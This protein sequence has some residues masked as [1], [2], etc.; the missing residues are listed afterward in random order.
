M[1]H[2]AATAN[3]CSPNT[4]RS[5][6]LLLYALVKRDGVSLIGALW[7]FAFTFLDE[8]RFVSAVV[9]AF[10]AV[11]SVVFALVVERFRLAFNGY[12]NNI[13]KMDG[14]MK[15]TIAGGCSTMRLVQFSLG[16]AALLS[17]ASFG[18]VVWPALRA[19]ICTN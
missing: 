18:Y 16:C 6:D 8:S 10:A 4:L 9:T 13:N 3:I 15:V 17:I 1:P 14:R 11:L 7:Y 5:S 12:I 2:K 19:L